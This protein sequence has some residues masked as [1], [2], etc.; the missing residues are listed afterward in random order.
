MDILKDIS[1]FDTII[2]LIQINKC[3]KVNEYIRKLKNKYEIIIKPEIEQIS[4]DKLK[5]PVEIIAKFA[6]LIFEQEGDINF[7]LVDVNKLSIRYLIYN[8]LIKLCKG[9]KY[10]IMKDYIFSRYLNNI[11][12]IDN[13]IIFID[14]LEKN[15]KEKFLKELM[16]KRK[17]AKDEFYKAEE[18]DKINLLCALYE[19]KK[20]E[21]IPPEI[22]T[23]LNE[24]FEDLDH[25][26]INKKKIRRIF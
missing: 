4:K 26:I 1:S 12:N 17:F 8:E 19:N 18:N 23:T 14:N 22:E 6:K 25:E 3:R 24:I 20:L 5:K 16:K 21:R 9:D 10:K 2:D 7:L 13:I 11:K 15:D